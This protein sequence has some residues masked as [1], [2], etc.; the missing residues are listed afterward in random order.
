MFCS[1][2]VEH[3][4][5]DGCLP[6]VSTPAPGFKPR[7]QWEEFVQSATSDWVR[8]R[9]WVSARRNVGG[10]RKHKWTSEEDT[11]LGEA[12]TNWGSN[13]WSRVAQMIPGRSGKQCR[14]RWLGRLAPDV[15]LDGWSPDEDLTLL[16]KQSELG[17]HWAKIKDFLPGRSIVSVKNRWNWLCRRDIPNHP[18]EFEAI[19]ISH[20][21]TAPRKSEPDRQPPTRPEEDL[22]RRM[23]LHLWGESDFLSF[24]DMHF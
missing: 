18:E 19:A 10:T 4:N 16:S 5:D 22:A 1:L 15:L 12:V 14:E 7:T 13:N 2:K 9:T 11:K 21:D 17:N 8:R 23:G 6:A 24:W 20:C 3:K